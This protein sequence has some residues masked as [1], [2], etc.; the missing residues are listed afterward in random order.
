[1][2]IYHGV[3]DNVVDPRPDRDL[4]KSLKGVIAKNARYFEYLSVGYNSW[5]NAFAEPDLLPWLFSFKN[6][7]SK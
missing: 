7:G 1:V 2:W 3:I 6:Q 5:I 4:I